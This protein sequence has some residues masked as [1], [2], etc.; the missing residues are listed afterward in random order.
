M[1]EVARLSRR[2][3]T[4]WNERGLGETLIKLVDKLSVYASYPYKRATYAKE[5]FQYNGKTFHYAAFPYTATW[6]NERCVEV[7]IL[8]DFLKN[9][10]GERVLE[11]GNVS[12]YFGNFSHDVVDKYEKH[13][14]A[15]N[16]DIIDFAPEQPYDAIV[17]ISTLEHIGFD[18]EIKDPD[19]PIV[20]LEALKRMVKNP[21]N[22]LIG[23]PIGYNRHLDRAL[24]ENRLPFDR[25][26]FMRRVDQA[27]H[28]VE[29]NQ[30][31]A[32]A[33]PYGAKY[34]GANALAFG[35]GLH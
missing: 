29:T 27:N 5:S 8:L 3:F 23:F 10:Q 6:R 16:L 7:P 31:E 22:V 15:R 26:L 14:D 4:L 34:L 25:I 1:S 32:L 24:I 13:R 9:H 19:K 28:W 33:N 30:A 18:E 20:A 21:S 17:S 2:F 11:L 12:R 35:I